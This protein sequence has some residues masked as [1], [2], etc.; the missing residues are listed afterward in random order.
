MSDETPVPAAHGE[1]TL[2]EFQR[3]ID[4][5]Y[6]EKDRGR[7]LEGTFL[8][9]H[10]EVGEL[11]RAVRRGHDRA[12][13]EEE[14]ADVLAWLVSTASILGVEMEAAVERKYGKVWK[15]AGITSQ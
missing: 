5:V 8:W 9:F 3:R 10:E 2:A 15:Q 6:G 4:A 12:N 11:T 13:L 7:G 14:F 1:L